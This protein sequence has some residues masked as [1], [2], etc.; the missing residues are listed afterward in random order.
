MRIT[1]VWHIHAVTQQVSQKKKKPTVEDLQPLTFQDSSDSGPEADDT[2]DSC[3]V[4]SLTLHPNAYFTSP[5]RVLPSHFITKVQ[6][7]VRPT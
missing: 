6:Y 7:S 2:A 3:R 1:L 4:N 5:H